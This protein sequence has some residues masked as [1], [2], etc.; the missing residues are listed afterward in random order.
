VQD[1]DYRL[2]VMSA[3]GGA[4]LTSVAEV[5]LE[6]PNAFPLSLSVLVGSGVVAALGA[7][8]VTVAITR[9]RR[10]TTA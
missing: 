2:V 10:P 4:G 1:G 3:D 5:Q 7:G 6:L 8:L 9:R